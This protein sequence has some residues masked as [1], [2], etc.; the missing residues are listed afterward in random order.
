MV[1]RASEKYALGRDPA[2]LIRQG[3]RAPLFSFLRARAAQPYF[4]IL[5]AVALVATIS[6]YPIGYAAFLSL[7]RTRYL[8]R[9][10]FIGLGNYW[11]LLRDAAAR[12]NLTLSLFYVFGS[13]VVVLPFSLAVALLLNQPIRFRAVFRT[14]IILPWAV[15][16]TI[17]A[18]LWSWLLN[19]DFGPLIYLLELLGLGR[20]APLSEGHLALPV[21][22]AVNAWGSYPMAVILILAALQTI[23]SEL[24]DA[25]RVD[26]TD[27]WQNFTRITLPL[28]RPT[29]LV[30]TILLSLHNFNMVTLVF[31]LTGGGPLGATELLSLRAF[32]EGF[33]FW[34]IGYS[35]ALGILIFVFNL[36]FSLLYIRLL[37]QERLY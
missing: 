16:Q 31:I 22:V 33:E 21:L 35:A 13:L 8:E 19:P 29:L 2:A 32:K 18:L 36:V 3:F 14:V 4:F 15:S 20:M 11:L 24:T 7:F 17:I 34:R 1:A 25:A 27:R 26:G 12:H 23:P 37:R 30:T 9:I 10:A 28:I 5:P 6:V